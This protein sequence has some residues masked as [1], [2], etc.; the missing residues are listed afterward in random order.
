MENI[1]P[2][3]VAKAKKRRKRLV[4]GIQ[5]PL[6]LDISQLKSMEHV[7]L[8]TIRASTKFVDEETQES[9]SKKIGDEVVA[10][11]TAM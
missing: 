11:R 7:T 5:R 3:E 1:F 9:G 2:T 4:Q 6:Y 10:H 8:H